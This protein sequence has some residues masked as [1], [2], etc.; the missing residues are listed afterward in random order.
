MWP[1]AVEVGG[2]LDVGV[3][4]EVEKEG[5]RS[6]VTAAVDAVEFVIVRVTPFT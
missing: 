1:R 3:G 6:S 4:V 5:C 2:G